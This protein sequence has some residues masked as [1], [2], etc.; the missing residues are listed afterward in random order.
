MCSVVDNIA[1]IQLP[2]WIL[3]SGYVLHIVFIGFLWVFQFPPT[4]ELVDGLATLN[5]P[6]CEYVYV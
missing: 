4:S 1:V 2:G 3:R 6:N 5:C